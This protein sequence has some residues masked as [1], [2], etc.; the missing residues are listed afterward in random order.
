MKKKG[1]CL[2]FCFLFG[3]LFA[4]IDSLPAVMRILSETGNAYHPVFSPFC[5]DRCW[6]NEREFDLVSRRFVPKDSAS[7]IPVSG[8]RI[9][10]AS[11]PLAPIPTRLWWKADPYHPNFFWTHEYRQ[12]YQEDWMN[13]VDTLVIWRYDL[14]KAQQDS[15][16]SIVTGEINIGKSGIW[17]QN[18]KELI[19]LDRLTGKVITRAENP[20]GP[21][22]GMASQLW[23]DDLLVSDQLLYNL[24]RRDF[25]PFFPLPSEME[26]CKSPEKLEIQGELCLSKVRIEG[27]VYIYHLIA[28]GHPPIKLPFTPYYFPYQNHLLAVNP[29]LAWLCEKDTLIAFDYTNGTFQAYPG[30]T[31]T[32]LFG[33]HEGRFLGFY[34]ESGLSFFDKYSCQFRVLQLPFGHKTPRN[35]TS[36]DQFIILTYE[37]HW[38]IID[39]S[40]LDI[41]FRRS[42][43]LEEYNVFEQEWRGQKQSAQEDFYKTYKAYVAIYSRYKNSENPK[44]KAAQEKFTSM[45]SYPL[46]VAPDSVMERVAKDF[47]M[48][49]FDPS[50]TCKIAQGLL[51]YFGKNG[52]LEEA[53]SL[54]AILENEPCFNQE[55]EDYGSEIHLI[56]G[57]KHQL[58][59]LAQL[60]LSADEKLYATGQIWFEFSLKKRWFWYT[61]DPRRDLEQAYDYFRKL[62]QQ[63]PN[64][65][66]ADNAAYALFHYVD[67]RANTTDDETPNGDDRQAYL[68]FTQFLKDYPKAEQKPSVLL[69]LAIVMIRGMSDWD[70]D[71]ATAAQVA[72]YLDAIAQEYPEFA[73]KESGYTK[74]LGDLNWKNWSMRWSLKLAITKDT[75]RFQ[76]TI[77]VRLGLR[78]HTIHNQTLDSNFLLTWREGLRLHLH[79]IRDK[80]C[81]Q[82]WGDF[83][84]IPVQSTNRI[85]SI[86]L[87]PGAIYEET[88]MLAQKS[89][90]KN[91]RPGQFELVRQGTYLYNMSY[92][93]PY[94]KWLMMYAPGGR[95][96]IE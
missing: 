12:D 72:E 4:Q 91:D 21:G 31:N 96:F 81:D 54:L 58:D 66:W 13:R 6:L 23:G 89:I 25:V 50:V 77:Q 32:P 1:F 35:F 46:Y 85:H 62:I 67:Y 42:S 84:L 88:F 27:N 15:F 86:T 68:S 40:K 8:Q 5:N 74:A 60:N 83:P 39:F 38:E 16:L 9:W 55:L 87:A 75:F 82:I 14:A 57:T 22:R 71:P 79:Q 34:S 78:N 28:P 52:R 17:I 45:I 26:G 94:L 76:D 24:V 92:R 47:D 43:I 80:D 37:D 63:Y 48:G 61:M 59:S 3:K 18:N 90:N 69:R 2:V 93:H 53:Y 49:R 30:S 44:I 95:F 29:P 36:T 64:S 19:L 41:G 33:T 56:K 10:H 73:K 7:C 51:R 20:F 11:Y 70:F 65:P